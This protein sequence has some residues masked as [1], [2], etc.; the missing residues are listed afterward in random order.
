MITAIII[1]SFILVIL[2]ILTVFSIL[3][4]QQL[5][6]F[7]L[8]NG[9]YQADEYRKAVAV[10]KVKRPSLPAVKQENRGRNVVATDELIDIAD[11]PW[12]E[13]MKIVEELGNG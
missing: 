4:Y 3:T 2:V 9:A 8:L 13:G 12:E 10:S 7:N 11:L 1:G 6:K 5:A